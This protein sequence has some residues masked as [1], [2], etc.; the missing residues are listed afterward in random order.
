MTIEQLLRDPNTELS[1]EFLATVLGD[2][3]TLWN[4]FNERLQDFDISLEWRYYKDGGWL[5]KATNKKRTIFWGSLS[6][7]FFSA[8]FNFPEKPHLRTGLLELD[9]SEDIKNSLSSTPKGAFWGFTVDVHSESQLSDLY[10]I[11]EYK[12]SAK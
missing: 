5:G 4:A 10:K 3:L 7:G 2:K 8:S 11:I 9:I 1:D 6:D 12:K